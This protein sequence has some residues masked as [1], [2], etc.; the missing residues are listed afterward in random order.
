MIRGRDVRQY[1]LSDN[2][3]FV[4]FPY[5]RKQGVFELYDE[6]TLN[7][8]FPRTHAY[9]VTHKAALAKRVWFGKDA[10]ELAGDWFGLMYTDSSA[11]FKSPH[12]LTPSLSNKS[13]FALGNRCCSRGGTAGVTSIIPN[14]ES[15]NIL[16]LLGLLNSSLLSFYI[17]QHSP[18]FQGAYRKFGTA[19][20]EE[21]THRCD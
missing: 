17:T 14:R 5:S 20:P 6:R 3:R 11:A 13:N 18:V 9:L 8:Q 15:E 1:Q 21:Y 16:Y 4:I 10:K 2:P 19:V 7:S 12:L